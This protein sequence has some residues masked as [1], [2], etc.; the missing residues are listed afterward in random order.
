MR[1]THGAS[2]GARAHHVE[3]RRAAAGRNST[4]DNQEARDKTMKGRRGGFF[5]IY[6]SY[7][8]I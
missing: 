4:P 7:L 2:L 5:F 1:T 8:E 6:I 3:G